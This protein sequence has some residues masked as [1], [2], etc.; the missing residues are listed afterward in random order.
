[1]QTLAL[2][3]SFALTGAGAFVCIRQV[4]TARR[5]QAEKRP[6][7]IEPDY[8]AVMIPDPQDISPGLKE[9]VHGLD[10]IAHHAGTAVEQA[11]HGLHVN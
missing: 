6:A 10:A 7:M 4:L 1:M 2:L 8:S 5:W 11:L 9:S 3:V